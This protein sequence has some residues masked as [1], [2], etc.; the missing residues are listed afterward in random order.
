VENVI[1]LTGLCAVHAQPDPA[2]TAMF[3][4]PDAAVI[5]ALVGEMV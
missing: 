1:Q 5:E 3:P 2:V 4:V